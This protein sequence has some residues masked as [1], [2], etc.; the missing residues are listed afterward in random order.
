MNLAIIHPKVSLGVLKLGA[1]FDHSDKLYDQLFEEV[2][3]DLNWITYKVESH[4]VYIS[5]ENEA[6]ECISTY[7]SC[8]Y[9]GYEL[10]GKT[11]TDLDEI[12]QYKAKQE[13]DDIL[14]DDG[15][16]Q[17]P[18]EYHELGLQ[19]WLHC[20]RVFLVSLQ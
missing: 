11:K 14:L 1:P 20:N 13:F 18:L 3:D 8:T 12:L 5:V 6:I 7:E 15:S 19:V 2:D 16:I 17:T 9:H 4:E 10:I